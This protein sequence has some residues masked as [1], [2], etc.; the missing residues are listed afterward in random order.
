MVIYFPHKFC[1]N[2]RCWRNSERQ[3]IENNIFLNAIDFA[4]ETFYDVHK[5]V[6]K[7]WSYADFRSKL[8]KKYPFRKISRATLTF[9]IL[10]ENSLMNWSICL[11]YFSTNSFDIVP[12]GFVIVKTHYFWNRVERDFCIHFLLHLKY[13]CPHLFQPNLSSDLSNAQL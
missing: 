8:N 7:M 13:T 2:K 11:L 5:H 3:F 6:H 1:K 12:H 10:K 4:L 9:S